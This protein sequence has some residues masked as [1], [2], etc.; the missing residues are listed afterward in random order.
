MSKEIN[1]SDLPIYK[2]AELI[3]DFG[4]QSLNTISE[5]EYLNATKYMMRDDAAIIWC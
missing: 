4:K 1:Y 2:K 3:L 5:D